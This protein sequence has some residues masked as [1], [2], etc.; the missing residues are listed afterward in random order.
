MKIAARY[1]CADLRFAHGRF[2]Q[3]M[4]TP[5][6]PSQ[7]GPFGVGRIGST[8]TREALHNLS[9]IELYIEA[10]LDQ[11]L[12]QANSS[13]LEVGT[14]HWK[15][16]P[17]CRQFAKRTRR[18][19]VLFGDQNTGSPRPLLRG[20]FICGKRLGLSPVHIAPTGEQTTRAP[21]SAKRFWQSS[22]EK[23]G[24]AGDVTTCLGAGDSRHEEG[25][26]VSQDPPQ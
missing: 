13:L 3:R 19:V 15:E 24:P 14:G 21:N 16:A 18:S 22:A 4:E 12:N 10:F 11:T 5:K 20:Q 25:R 17:K 8:E 6:L 23:R 2:P 26:G 1:C 7:N 9:L